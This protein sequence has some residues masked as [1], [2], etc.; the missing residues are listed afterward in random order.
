MT[1]T[2]KVV[3]TDRTN[4]GGDNDPQVLLHFAPDYQ[5]EANKEWAYYTPALSLQMTVRGSV[6]DN[7]PMGQK[8]TLRFDIEDLD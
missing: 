5:D 4:T 1:V 7:F 2:A 8:V 6:A 3:V